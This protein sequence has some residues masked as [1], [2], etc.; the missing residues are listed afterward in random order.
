MICKCGHD[1]NFHNVLGN[2][3]CHEMTCKCEHYEEAR[4]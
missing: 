2:W 1:I 3:A 4:R